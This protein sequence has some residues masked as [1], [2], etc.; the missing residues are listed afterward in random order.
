MD[1]SKAK[2]TNDGYFVAFCPNGSI[3]YKIRE[4]DVYKVT[5]GFEHPNLLSYKFA[6]HIFK[7]NPYLILTD[8]WDFNESLIKEWDGLSQLIGS[9]KDG[10]ELLIIAKP[11]IKI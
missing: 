4:P 5:W 7:E 1:L 11:N 9:K 6:S 10:K 8:D 3:E 2:L